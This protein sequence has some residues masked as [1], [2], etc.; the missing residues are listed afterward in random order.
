VSDSPR[1]LEPNDRRKLLGHTEANLLWLLLPAAH[2]DGSRYSAAVNVLL[3]SEMQAAIIKAQGYGGTGSGGS[4]PA[5]PTGS[6]AL[7]GASCE[8]RAA[9]VR[10][11]WLAELASVAESVAR[12]RAITAERLG[13][14]SPPLPLNLAT[15]VRS[16][17]WLTEAP[18]GRV[19]DTDDPESDHAIWFARQTSNAVRQGQL[20]S[21][22]GHRIPSVSSVL[23]A[24]RVAM[25][26]PV[27]PEPVVQKPMEGCRSCKRNA[28]HFEPIDV[29]RYSK[30]DLC[31]MCG[32]YY[33]ANGEIPPLA[34]VKYVHRTG[35][36]LT[37]KVVEEAK[38]SERQPISEN[39][40]VER[41]RWHK[42]ETTKEEAS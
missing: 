15:T 12:V 39:R 18:Q 2:L 13:E 25:K 4:G 9:A 14:S 3:D 11:V 7:A 30:P 28:G 34:A 42:G 29:V 20:T 22:G 24:A 31:T 41:T 37:T 6:A 32:N 21:P 40:T 35:K 33:A 5:D 38:R 17:R 23:E 10:R 1:P 16:I 26:R 36:R 27:D 8:V 19:L